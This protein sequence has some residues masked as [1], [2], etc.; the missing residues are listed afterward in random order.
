MWTIQEL[1]KQCKK[2]HFF[3]LG[4]IQLK[5]N[6]H[7]R[8]H[9]Y[10]TKYS[11]IVEDTEIH[12]HRYDFTSKV[13]LG[14]LSNRTYSHQTIKA[15][16]KVIQSLNLNNPYPHLLHEVS[17]DP[18]RPIKNKEPIECII[19]TPYSK[20]YDKGDI[21]TL[22]HNQFHKVRTDEDTITLLLRSG[23]KQEFAHVIRKKGDKETC[24]FSKQVPEE[25]LWQIV[26]E[27]WR[28]I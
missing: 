11:P 7:L 24:P 1:K 23:Y 10:T 17:C 20:W 21:Y 6:D 2:I 12:D 14:G 4:F 26:E 5:L 13:L 22:F 27:M 25:E 18:N 28:K 19:T 9:F 3:G 15:T 16:I 8:L